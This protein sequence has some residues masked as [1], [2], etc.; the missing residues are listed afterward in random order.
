MNQKN[1]T[2]ILIII[3]I[4]LTG[5]TMYF[6]LTKNT[7]LPVAVPVAVQQQNASQATNQ[8][9]GNP[10]TES[11]SLFS[12]LDG[13]YTFEYPAIWKAAINKY[14]KNNSLFGPNANSGSG[15]G[16]VEISENQTSIDNFLESIDAQYS[17]KIK[18]TADGVSGIRTHYE[19]FP[20]KGEQAVFFK[21]NRIY[22][23]YMNSEKTEDRKLF[24]Q[25][26]S[27][28]KFID[29]TTNNSGS[30]WKI[31][32]GD[33]K[34]N[35]SQVTYKGEVQVRGWYV[36]DYNYVEKQWMFRILTEDAKKIPVID[37]IGQEAYDKWLASNPRFVLYG[38]TPE[39]EK[40]LKAASEKNPKTITVKGLKIYCEGSPQLSLSEF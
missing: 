40:E 1:V 32:S 21:N 26:I 14:N 38:A 15:L 10:T 3:I 27:T 37:Y 16:G 12:N 39:L 18:I 6:A 29:K 25:L 4:V 36:Y 34:E 7:V 5:T 23:I 22:S 31:I 2:L 20:N 33:P 17:N 8:P 19:G 30:G 9:V 24:D 13:G 28:F 11:I 35:C